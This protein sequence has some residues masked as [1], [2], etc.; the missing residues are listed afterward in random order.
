MFKVHS[1]F[2]Y[3]WRLSTFDDIF[4][5]LMKMQRAYVNTIRKIFLDFFDIF[6]KI[7]FRFFKIF[8]GILGTDFLVIF[9]ILLFFFF[10]NFW[11]F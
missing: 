4:I 10:F 3:G 8:F 6:L 7:F 2:N 9:N 5:L 1:S 11:I